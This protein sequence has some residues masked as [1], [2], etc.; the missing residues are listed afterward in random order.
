MRL[1][2]SLFAFALISCAPSFPVPLSG[3][4]TVPSGNLVTCS[5]APVFPGFSGFDISQSQAFQNQGATKQNIQ[6]VKLSSLALTVTSPQGSN[7]GFLTSLSFSV[8]D[9]S[10]NLPTVEIAHANDF[11]NNPTSVNMTVDGAELAPY[12]ELPSMDI[13]SQAS[14]KACPPQD[15]TIQASLVLQVTLK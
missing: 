4:A 11:S 8:S 15:T 3:S 2:L 14:I 13:T 12:A 9:P 1:S 5:L 10:G 7:L 6:S